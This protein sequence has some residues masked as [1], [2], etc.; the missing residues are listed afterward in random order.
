MIGQARRILRTDPDY[1]PEECPV[2]FRITYEGPL[3]A[4]TNGNAPSITSTT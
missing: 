3:Y 2:Q 4:Q 1:H